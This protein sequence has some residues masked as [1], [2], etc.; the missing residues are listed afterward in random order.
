MIY[1]FINQPILQIY[2]RSMVSVYSSTLSPFVQTFKISL[3][4]FQ[5]MGIDS[6]GFKELSS[7]LVVIYSFFYSKFI[8]YRRIEFKG[9]YFLQE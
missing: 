7:H 3:E 5:T 9:H 2:L 4:P 8:F 6:L 1:H